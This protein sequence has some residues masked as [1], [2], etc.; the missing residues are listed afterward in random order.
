MTTK[1][2]IVTTHASAGGTR[3]VI[4]T[5]YNRFTSSG[6]DV[7][8]VSLY[9]G[10]Q[11]RCDTP[12]DVLIP[13][14]NLNPVEYLSATAR[15]FHY[16]IGRRPDALI[17]VLPAANIIGSVIGFFIGIKRRFATQHGPSSSQHRFLRTIDRGLGT[18][19]G[20]TKVVC[21]SDSVRT[22]FDRYP[23]RY[24]NRIMVILNGIG[25]TYQSRSR[26]ELRDAFA[27]PH[28]TTLFVMVGRLT[29]EKNV[30][31]AVAAIA[32]VET[33]YLLIVGDGPMEYGARELVEQHRAE[34]RI[35]F[36]G[37]VDR[38]FAIDCMYAADVF[39]Q[40]SNFEGRS[41]ALLEA[42]QIGMAVLVSD[43]RGQ[44]EVLE[45]PSG[46][47]LAGAI[48]EPDDV[49]SIERQVRALTNHPATRKKFRSLALQLRASCAD[50]ETMAR[51]YA[52]MVRAA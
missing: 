16:L 40:P 13:K 48:C 41:I 37:A 24:R 18:L 21:V 10:A 8:I 25:P 39:Y 51:Q 27:I 17:T 43:V 31:R 22:S 38:Q 12:I 14:K 5:L 29:E 26:N 28:H 47:E 3:E 19:G 42:I 11:G 9:T 2:A 34:N 45:M 36:A 50:S 46:G 15:L 33:S 30:L 32:R 44:V 4:S 52:D 23:L 6:W 7:R 49:E 1:L 20:Y 35:K